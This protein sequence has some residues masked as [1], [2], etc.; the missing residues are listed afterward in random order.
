[1]NVLPGRAS[2]HLF[3]NLI[4]SDPPFAIL[5]M[6]LDA[7]TGTVRLHDI[8]TPL[9]NV[10]HV[11]RDKFSARYQ[12]NGK[13][14][15][16][17]ACCEADN[18]LTM[19]FTGAVRTTCTA[20]P[21][22]IVASTRGGA[23][24][25]AIAARF[26]GTYNL[27]GAAEALW[28]A[29]VPFRWSNN[30]TNFSNLKTLQDLLQIRAMS[31]FEFVHYAAYL[32]GRQRTAVRRDVDGPY[33][34]VTPAGPAGAPMIGASGA[35]VYRTND[36]FDQS[37]QIARENTSYVGP[38]DIPRGKVIVFVAMLFNNPDGYYHVGISVGNGRCISLSSGT[39]LDVAHLREM[40]SGAGMF[41]TEVRISDYN[42]RGAQ[43]DGSAPAPTPNHPH[44]LR[45][46]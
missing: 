25:A 8:T 2:W 33:T 36:Y 32:A 39:N 16:F 26:K 29:K 24:V 44:P 34:D 19:T 12:I 21:I 28:Q 10:T 45:F 35:T 17:E 42:W 37:F 38:I 18:N 9:S 22:H 41:Y 13:I 23:D 27:A 11:D 30:A 43:Q 46:R 15:A 5:D 31:C 1:M 40:T 20:K 4:G 3:S 7:C 14:G 6:D